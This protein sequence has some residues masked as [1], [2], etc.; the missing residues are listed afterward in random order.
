MPHGSDQHR[1]VTLR[2]TTEEDRSR[3]NDLLHDELGAVVRRLSLYQPL[4]GPPVD[5]PRLRRSFVALDGDDL[6]GVGSALASNRHPGRNQVAVHV[7]RSHRRRGVGRALLGALDEAMAAAGH[8]RPWQV[9]VLDTD[10]TS[11]AVLHHLGWPL[12]T[13]SRSGTLDVT[14]STGRRE[15]PSGIRIEQRPGLDDEL[16]DLYEELYDA[17]HA[18][19]QPY[20]RNAGGVP[21]IAFLGEPLDGSVHVAVDRQGR[22]VSV[23]SLHGDPTCPLLAPTGVLP[24]GPA[25]HDVV[26]ALVTA[27]LRFA[28]AAGIRELE[29]EA[30]DAYE[31]LWLA[32]RPHSLDRWDD[33]LVHGSA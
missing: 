28:Q 3:I 2:P 33:L 15:A 4:H 12:L 19:A 20:V 7:H 14:A 9:A 27:V 29:W 17:H 26:A 31:H 32:L 10:S 30:D 1:G 21:W 6:I 8:A 22:A 13:T 11:L 18:W 5:A 24:G 25:G 23:A 16:V